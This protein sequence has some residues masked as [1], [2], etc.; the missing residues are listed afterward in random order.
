MVSMSAVGNIKRSHIKLWAKLV[1]LALLHYSFTSCSK[2]VFLNKSDKLE[3]SLI[4]T[5]IVYTPGDTLVA[6]LE[7]TN[8][9]TLDLRIPIQGELFRLIRVHADK[10][11]I[12]YPEYICWFLGAKVANISDKVEF[13]SLR[14]KEKRIFDV[15]FIEECEEGYTGQ[16]DFHLCYWVEIN[17]PEE[18]SRY[19]LC[20]DNVM[21]ITWR[22]N[23]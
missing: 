15:G 9:D 16:L 11:W 17:M 13:F 7:I 4:D 21:W 12:G 2:P 3:L 18:K 19:H 6:S 10:D 14:P 22:A 8:L 1:L 20:S 23:N 5:S